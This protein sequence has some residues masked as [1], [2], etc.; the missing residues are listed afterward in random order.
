MSKLEGSKRSIYLDTNYAMSWGLLDDVPT[1]QLGPEIK[2]L[3]AKQSEL[4]EQINDLKRLRSNVSSKIRTLEETI[5]RRRYKLL[6]ENFK[7][8]EDHKKI[9]RS[10]NW[11]CNDPYRS[12]D[13]RRV[14]ELLDYQKPND[15]YSDEQYEQANR[16]IDEVPIALAKFFGGE[17]K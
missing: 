2:R 16:L 12:I 9:I 1:D 17:I 7:L 11:E 14:C 3:E 8:T 13:T 4:N 15:D 5:S 6:K 10:M